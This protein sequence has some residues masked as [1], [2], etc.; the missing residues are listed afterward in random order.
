[1]ED[2]RTIREVIRTRG[3]VYDILQALVAEHGIGMVLSVFEDVC[4]IQATSLKVHGKCLEK[5]KSW[6]KIGKQIA[7]IVTDL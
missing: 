1:M 4:F 2:N 3:Q 6:D 7:R 5:A